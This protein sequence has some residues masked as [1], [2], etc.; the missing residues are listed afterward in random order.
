MTER[1]MKNNNKKNS[2]IEGWGRFLIKQGQTDMRVGER[3]LTTEI[4]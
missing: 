4:N 2:V 3:E 1:Q